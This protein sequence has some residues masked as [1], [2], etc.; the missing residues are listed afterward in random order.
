[1]LRKSQ[2][3]TI[4]QYF[5]NLKFDIK[6]DNDSLF[7]NTFLLIYI[8]LLKNRAFE[9]PFFLSIFLYEIIY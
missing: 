1:M 7:R 4:F 5:K 2:F 6:S 8:F 3:F 9:T